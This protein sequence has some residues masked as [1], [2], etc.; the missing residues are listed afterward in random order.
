MHRA[1]QKAYHMA[2]SR[3][4]CL[5]RGD[6]WTKVCTSISTQT[7]IADS[8]LIAGVGSRGVPGT[9]G[10]VLCFCCADSRAAPAADCWRSL[11]LSAGELARKLKS[12]L[13]QIGTIKSRGGRSD[14]NLKGSSHLYRWPFYHHANPGRVGV[15]RSR[16]S[17]LL[18]SSGSLD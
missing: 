5:T 15:S 7:L 3:A 6:M 4:A 9:S 18:L 2:H 16:L 14:L 1:L 12:L 8:V 11:L 17:R 13:Y 10:W